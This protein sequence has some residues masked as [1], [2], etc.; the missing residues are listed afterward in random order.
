MQGNTIDNKMKPG[1][2][3]E[4]LGLGNET[5]GAYN[6]IAVGPGGTANNRLDQTGGGNDT[7]N[8]YVSALKKEENQK[9]ETGGEEYMDPTALD[10]KKK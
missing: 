2:A 10:G 1:G 6:G 3:N 7:L 9:S 5:I 4:T 8:F